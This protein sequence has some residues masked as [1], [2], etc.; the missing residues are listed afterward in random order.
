MQA[1]RAPVQASGCCPGCDVSLQHRAG[2][3]GL[4][5]LAL[6]TS[7]KL[8]APSS[9][10][11][12]LSCRGSRRAPSARGSSPAS[13]RG[14][15][16]GS[17][18]HPHRALRRVVHISARLAFAIAHA[19]GHDAFCPAACTAVLACL[20]GN[21]TEDHASASA[22]ATATDG[23]DAAA[24]ASCA[25]WW[26]PHRAAGPGGL[27]CAARRRARGR[28]ACRRRRRQ[29]RRRPS[30]GRRGR[31]GGRSALPAYA[32]LGLERS[33]SE[34]AV[35]AA[36]RRRALRLHPDRFPNATQAEREAATRRFQALAGAYETL[37][38]PALRAEYDAASAE[39]VTWRHA[40]PDWE[41]AVSTFAHRRWTSQV[42]RWRGCTRR[43][44]AISRRMPSEGWSRAEASP[45]RAPSRT[46]SC[47]SHPYPNPKPKPISLSLTLTLTEL[48]AS[49]AASERLAASVAAQGMGARL[50]P[51]VAVRRVVSGTLDAVSTARAGAAARRAFGPPPSPNADAPPAAT[52]TAAAVRPPLPPRPRWSRSPR[53]AL[54]PRRRGRCA[55]AASVSEFFAFESVTE[56]LSSVGAA[57]ADAVDAA[58]AAIRWWFAGESAQ[59]EPVASY[60]S[61][62]AAC[63]Y[64]SVVTG[65]DDWLG[66]VP[67]PVCVFGW[68]RREMSRISFP[69]SCTVLSVAWCVPCVDVFLLSI[70]ALRATLYC[71]YLYLLSREPEHVFSF[72]DIYT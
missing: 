16:H 70:Y 71:L 33:A 50:I 47:R 44:A 53:R 34:G 57:A 14:R 2:R 69:V 67:L 3:A 30:R 60:R 42:P 36:Y 6:R 45:W 72:I 8:P 41:A 61:G 17:H 20:T 40:V 21:D 64:F 48:Q 1:S 56:S 54:W 15:H 10:P 39:G 22:E 49:L 62:G 46:P 51:V 23:A 5:F 13:R 9:P 59:A 27:S 55:A 52:A 26:S 19:H 28:G 43:R 66:G 4:S 35:R 31:R 7:T 18:Q 68:G 29:R 37:S 38:D 32:L 24:P 65:R 63:L 25:L 11:S 58:D 12:T